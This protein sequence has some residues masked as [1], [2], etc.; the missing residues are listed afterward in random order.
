MADSSNPPKPDGLPQGA[1]YEAPKPP[2]QNPAL[3]MMGMPNLRLRLPSRNWM[4]FLTIVGSWTAA[5]VYD[6]REKKKA[7]KKW[8][9]LVAHIAQEPLPANQMPRKLTVF[10]S[11]P[12]GDGI[13][14]SR[15][16]FKDYVKPVLVAA[17][18]D[19]DV[20]E[21]RK[22]GD[23]RYGTAEQIRRLRRKKGEKEPNSTEPEM[24]TEAAIDM[25]R[26]K[27]QIVPEPGVRGDL[28]LGRHTWKEY[29]RG[30][31][32]G[33]LGPVDEP[34]APPEPV[35]I[36][37]ADPLSPHPP[38]EVRTDSSPTA[39][40]SAEMSKPDSEKKASEEE[41]KEEEKKKP[42]PPPAYLSID[43]YPS[44]SLSPHTPSIFEPSQPIHQQHLLGFL[45]TPQRI[46]N[47]LTRRY[48]A[49]QIGRETAAIVLAASRPY[50]QSAST[51]TF[52]TDQSGLD[53]DPVATKAPES[54]AS[55][56]M[57]PSPQS[58][59]AWEQQSLLIQEEP[60]WH[61]SVRKPR[62]DDDELY[63]PIWMR[64]M[65]IDERIG[66]RM[67]KFQLDADEEA[68]ADRIGRGQEKAR[69]KEVVDLR[70]E[71]VIVGNLDDD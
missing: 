40:E 53:A 27:M 54:D 62:K 38:I 24:D 8:C 46:Y 63:E 11:A 29:I 21:G 65:V 39:T 37:E 55:S 2:K 23:V 68:R 31:H 44:A 48:L 52:F 18:M 3:R 6:R 61:K 9:D 59:T 57:S 67:R 58:Q 14:P 36:S 60:K 30:L 15:Q 12:P 26:D 35:S 7:Q 28:V 49:D 41:K 1:K 20:I 25:I 66:S 42:Y 50:E 43:K 4:I 34:P 10:L 32:E 5:V 71:K 70:N 56:S 47:F 13:R 69:V 45:K 33:W 17:A 16:Y 22:E 64:D 51:T 19:Y